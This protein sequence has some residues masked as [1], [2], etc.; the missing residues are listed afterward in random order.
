VNCPMAVHLGVYALGSADAAERLLVEAHLPGC[1]SCRAE[2]ARL[3]PLPDL[4]ARVP[5]E[6][7][8]DAA[9]GGIP[10]ARLEPAADPAGVHPVRVRAADARSTGVRPAARPLAALRRAVAGAPRL[11]RAWRVAA[12]AAVTAA[13]AGFAGGVW[14]LPH[15][16]AAI[17]ADVTMSAANP[18]THV[19]ATAALTAT[20]WGTSIRLTAD[21]LPLNQLCWLVVRDRYGTTEVTGY[22]DAWSAGPVSVPASAAWRPS[23]IASVQVVTKAGVLVTVMAQPVGSPAGAAGSAPPLTHSSG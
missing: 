3:A 5:E 9:M 4:L 10:P 19:R 14:L 11:A 12:T 15:G 1:S 13:A 17:P 8:A 21:G 20:S 7:L 18:A 6:M 23:D 22:W 2:L 16:A